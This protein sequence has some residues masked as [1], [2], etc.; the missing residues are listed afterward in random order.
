M[1][2]KAFFAYRR[3]ILFTEFFSH[4]HQLYI[5]LTAEHDM[6]HAADYIKYTL[7]NA[8]AADN[9]LD[10]VTEQI[11]LLSDLPQRF[12]LADDPVLANWGIRFIQINHYLAF[13]TIDEEN[14]SYLLSA[15]F[16]KKVIG[17]PFFDRDFPFYNAM[18]ENFYYTCKYQ[19]R[20]D[21]YG[22]IP[23]GHHSHGRFSL[24]LSFLSD[25]F[26]YSF[27]VKYTSS[28]SGFSAFSIFTAVSTGPG[29]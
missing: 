8:T 20:T 28:S 17:L 19:K 24:L 13:Y 11:L 6:I 22:I 9:L 10:T 18:F 27:Y 25:S 5:T 29:P 16:I 21:L 23:H 12:R 3:R 26:L 2:S 14:R 1:L 15:F 4:T 7:K